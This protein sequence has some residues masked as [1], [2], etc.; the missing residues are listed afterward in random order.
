[1]SLQDRI[2]EKLLNDAK[3]REL[4]TR[5]GKFSPSSFGKCFRAQVLNR[6]NVSQSNPPDLKTLQIFEGG[7]VLHDYVQQYFGKGE[8]EVKIESEH[9]VGYADLVLEDIVWDIKSTNPAYFFYSGFGEKRKEYSVQ[10]INE[11][12][13]KKKMSNILQVT[14]YAIELGKPRIGLIFISRDLSY[15]TRAHEWTG[16]TEDYAPLI[17]VEEGLL[18]KHWNKYK[19]DGTFPACNPRLYD[20]RE[21]NYCGWKDYCGSSCPKGKGA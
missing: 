17:R 10:E 14:K 5:S 11:I 1:M 4:R 3:Q 18:M 13:P 12:I 2:D 16:R 19:E 7:K 8:V 21:G 20:G 6:A 15:G 9:F